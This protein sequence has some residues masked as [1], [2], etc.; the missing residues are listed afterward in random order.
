MFTDLIL[1]ITNFIISTIDQLGYTGVAFLMAIESAAIPLP[2]EVIMP[3]SGFLVEAGRFTLFGLAVAGAVGSVVGSVAT[4]ALGY[5]GG[6]PLILKYGRYVLISENDL[7]LTEKFFQRFGKLSVFVGRMLPV[8]RTFISIP[9]G[10]G[11]VPLGSFIVI[12]FIGSFIW[13]YFL[14]WLGLKLGENWQLLE[15]YFRKFDAVIV[16]VIVAV[17]VWW[18]R[19]HIKSRIK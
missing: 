6:R 17:I 14:A 7:K 8:V 13:S 15:G 2:S 10:I 11:K 5:Y 12:A 19:R 16:I 18:I 1:A 9:A 3:F 4:Y